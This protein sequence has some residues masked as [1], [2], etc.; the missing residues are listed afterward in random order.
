MSF[1]HHNKRLEDLFYFGNGDEIIPWIN[2][3]EAMAIQAIAPLQTPYQMASIWSKAVRY[4]KWNRNGEFLDVYV[5]MTALDINNCVNN[6]VNNPFLFIFPAA[7]HALDYIH[8]K[9]DWFPDRQTIDSMYHTLQLRALQ[10]ITDH[11]AISDVFCADGR[12]RNIFTISSSS[13]K[14]IL[15]GDLPYYGAK[16]E[17]QIYRVELH[18]GYPSGMYSVVCIP[19]AYKI[20][21]MVSMAEKVISDALNSNA[22]N[23]NALNEVEAQ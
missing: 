12:I 18:H 20:E 6:C 13:L 4:H 14:P 9:S 19:Y 8:V 21:K 22:L 7:P 16:R 2:R 10:C 15:I 11:W 1:Y 23:S 5:T 17:N 3:R